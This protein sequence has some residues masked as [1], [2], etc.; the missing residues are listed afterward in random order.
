MTVFLN[1]VLFPLSAPGTESC[2]D[3]YSESPRY[4]EEAV[5]DEHTRPGHLV[6]VVVCSHTLPLVGV[7]NTIFTQGSLL[8]TVIF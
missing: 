3:K 8:I 4:L 2:G 5:L 1:R 7:H 6:T